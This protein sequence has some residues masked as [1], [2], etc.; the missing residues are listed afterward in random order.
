MES[1][2][3]K[4]LPS[5]EPYSKKF[6]DIY[7]SQQNGLAETRY[8]FLEGNH[9]SNRFKAT[10]GIFRIAETGFGT[11]LN[12]LATWQLLDQANNPDIFLDF[13]SVEKYPLSKSEL[14][15]A[16]SVWTELEDYSE[17]LISEYPEICYPGTVQLQ[18]A[19]NVLLTLIFDD[20]TNAFSSYQH[21]IDAWFL[22]GFAPSLNSDMWSNMLFKQM[23]RLSNLNDK[24]TTF[25]TF[26]AASNVRKELIQV[27]FDVKKR[28]G[29][30]KKREMLCGCFSTTGHRNI[31]QPIPPFYAVPKYDIDPNNRVAVIGAGL[32]GCALAYEFSKYNIKC[33]LF[34]KDKVIAN[35]ASGNPIGI[36][37]PYLSMDGNISDLFFTQGFLQ[38]KSFLKAN[39]DTDVF[40]LHSMYQ[41]LDSEKKEK[42]YQ[43]LISK[44]ELGDNLVK[45]L[46]GQE[47]VKQL[48]NINV[49]AALYHQ[50]ALAVNPKA[51]CQLWLDLAAGHAKLYLETTVEKLQK[52]D[53]GWL[54]SLSNKNTHNY[55]SVILAGG[56]EQFKHF[57]FIDYMSCLAKHGQVD[58]V[59]NPG[60][61]SI[62]SNKNYAVPINN[63][64]LLIGAT[65]RKQNDNLQPR[66]D[67]F[68]QNLTGLSQVINGV[69]YEP[70]YSR[71]SVRCTS[72]DHFPVV[73]GVI[74][75]N[76]FENIYQTAIKNGVTDNHL[77]SCPYQNGLYIAS[78][79]GSKG[80]SA[81]L[82][83]AQ[84][85]RAMILDHSLPC[86]SSIYKALQPSRFL[87]R[88]YRKKIF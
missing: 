1:P 29:F 83:S 52:S 58:V 48:E 35:G 57:K 32:A 76:E 40:K 4:W 20:A 46:I 81:S 65:F 54:V 71:V 51:L 3:I 15:Q 80:L 78:S 30:G 67:D 55:Q 33:D 87:V 84:I 13:V 59:N 64:E 74:N 88:S 37:H 18:L 41:I 25:A 62:I 77:E 66:F 22:D 47:V 61:N 7:F 12:F 26:T 63:D 14:K 19:P 79:F 75:Q 6:N 44:R 70:S 24:Q 10:N 11:G 68:R 9:L 82:I 49:N 39:A 50:E 56:Y 28:K 73:G 27:G 43:E 42:F 45:C 21:A 31:S 69:N 85:I 36:A 2:D 17:K 8:V 34:E 86:S 53:D 60:L 38:L 72:I 5:G 23:A 16:L